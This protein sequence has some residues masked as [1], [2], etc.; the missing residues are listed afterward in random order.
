M[1]TLEK[2]TVTLPRDFV[3]EIEQAVAAGEFADASEVIRDA[4]STWYHSRKAGMPSDDSLRRLTAE[5]RASGESVDGE[6][7]LK[8]LREKY[9]RMATGQAS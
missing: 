6:A 1:A 4:L 7:A 3:A 5:G 8:R 9:I 2:L